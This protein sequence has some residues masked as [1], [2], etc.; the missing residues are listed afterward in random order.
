MLDLTF[1]RMVQE[2]AEIIERNKRAMRHCA[3]CKERNKE[4][5]EK[6]VDMVVYVFIIII[7]C[8]LG[9]VAVF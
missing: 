3:F 2:R 5:L 6:R 9:Y 8:Y 1:V 7:S 4:K